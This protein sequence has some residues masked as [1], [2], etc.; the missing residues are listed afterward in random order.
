MHLRLVSTLTCLSLPLTAMVDRM[1]IASFTGL[2]LLGYSASSLADSED[3]TST[4]AFADQIPPASPSIRSPSVAWNSVCRRVLGRFD[5][6]RD[7]TASV[8][9]FGCRRGESVSLSF[10]ARLHRPV[11]GLE[12]D[13]FERKVQERAVD[14]VRRQLVL[15]SVRV[16]RQAAG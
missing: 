1:L 7:A 4:S 16:A 9:N 11:N 10:S 14:D 8:W 12:P 5:R 15:H 6:R 2:L 13:L 3:S